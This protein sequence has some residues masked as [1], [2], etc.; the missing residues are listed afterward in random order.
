MGRFSRAYP[1]TWS[2]QKIADFMADCYRVGRIPKGARAKSKRN[3]K[4]GM[5]TVTWTWKA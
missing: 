5:I 4:T 3:K 2:V 1:D